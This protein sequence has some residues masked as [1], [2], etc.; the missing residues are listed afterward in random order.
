MTTALRTASRP[1]LKTP[2]G[3]TPRAPPRRRQGALSPPRPPGAAIPR[4]TPGTHALRLSRLRLLRARQPP[5]PPRQRLHGGGAARAARQP[6]GPARPR[7]RSG[8]CRPPARG[9]A[10]DGGQR[11]RGWGGARSCPVRPLRSGLSLRL[12][13][14]ECGGRRTAQQVLSAVVSARP[15]Q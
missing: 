13:G 14:S 3:R 4:P 5:P 6:Q 11:A 10:G 12:C 1:G 15:E 7:C 9:G 8:H 2:K